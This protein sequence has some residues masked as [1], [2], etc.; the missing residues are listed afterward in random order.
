LRKKLPSD[1]SEFQI[2]LYAEKL[3]RE[4]GIPG[5]EDSSDGE[6][7]TECVEKKQKADKKA[8]ILLVNLK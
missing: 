1:P 7:D 5:F 2:L 8:V 6:S 3:A 4:E